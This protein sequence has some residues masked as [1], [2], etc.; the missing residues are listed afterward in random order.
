MIRSFSALRASILFI[1]ASFVLLLCVAGCVH[2]AL[3]AAPAAVVKDATVAPPPAVSKTPNTAVFVGD[4]A[5]AG[6]HAQ[7]FRDHKSSRHAITFHAADKISLGRLAPNTG[8]LPGTRARILQV[9][10][11][12]QVQMPG[13]GQGPLQYALG[14]GKSGMT[15]VLLMGSHVFE[16][17][18]SYFPNEHQWKITPGQKNISRTALGVDHRDEEARSCIQCHVTTLPPDSNIPEKR[19]YGVGCEACH[20]AGGAHVAAMRSGKT[21]D[22]QIERIGKWDA[23]RVNDLC[24]KCHRNAEVAGMA[25][26]ETPDLSVTSRFQ[27]YGLM[28]SRCFRESKNTLSCNTCHNP[29]QNTSHDMR[30]YEAACLSCHSGKKTEDGRRKTEDT[31]STSDSSLIPGVHPQGRTHPSSFS[32]AC[33]VNPRTGCVGCHMPR[34]PMFTGMSVTTSAPD[35]FIRVKRPAL[36]AKWAKESANTPASMSMGALGK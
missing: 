15:Y 9:G 7:A 32:K 29:H 33:P 14:S 34:K 26:G 6:C 22:I 3:P 25:A 31:P 24:G 36:E 16:M 4:Q 19:F 28:L 18:A 20:G 21:T 17:R 5:C 27:P 13:G 30:K 11:G 10:D 2:N 12:Y 8:P 1:V 35:H 23:K